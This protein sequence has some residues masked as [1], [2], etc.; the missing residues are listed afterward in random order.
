MRLAHVTLVVRDQDEAIAWFERALGFTVV[1]DTDLGGGKRWVLV[2]PPGDRSGT[3]LLLARAA[4]PAQV[5]RVGDPTGGRVAFFLHTDDL[6][7][8]LARLRANE[9]AITDGPRD[10]PYG[11]VAVFADLYGTRW[12]L[13]QPPPAPRSSP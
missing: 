6:E 13:I 8:D 12:D 3:A 2:A 10:E 5:A 11:R 9:V 1:E 4:T 7:R